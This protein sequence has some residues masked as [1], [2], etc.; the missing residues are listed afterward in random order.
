MESRLVEQPSGYPS[1]CVLSESVE[2]PFVETDRIVRYQGARFA[3][4]VAVVSELAQAA[5]LALTP[6]RVRA[7]EALEA[8][9]EEL[10]A[11][12]A[13]ATEDLVEYERLRGATATLLRQGAVVDKKGRIVPR[14]WPGHREP[15]GLDGLLHVDRLEMD[16]SGM[17]QHVTAE[18]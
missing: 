4:S 17:T 13:A 8:E 6:E 10:R 16:R 11:W 2:G 1:C 12:K 15:T 5:G 7:I 14:A 3:V 9:V 18:S